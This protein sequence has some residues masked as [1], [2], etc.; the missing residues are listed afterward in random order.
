MNIQNLKLG[1]LAARPVPYML[2]LT[3]YVKTTLPKP[4][5]SIAQ[6]A[7]VQNWGM[8]LNDTLGDCTCAGVGHGIQLLTAEN[9]CLFTPSDADIE[10][11]YEQSCG[12]NPAKPNTDRGGI[13]ADVLDY[14][15][16]HGV[17][18]HS[19]AEHA[20]IHVRSKTDI[21]LGIDLF[22][23]IYIGVALPISAQDQVGKVWDVTKGPESRP[24]TWGGHCIIC[25]D[26]DDV[27]LKC[28]T[29]G[30]VQT[31][32]WTWFKRYCDE[33]HIVLSNDWFTGDK[34]PRGFDSAALKADIAALK[35]A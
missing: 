31:M 35:R 6:S 2:T 17:A 33:A 13:C 14:W 16:E 5:V 12:Y 32:T 1:K 23:F 27:G 18:G 30:A 21:K 3:D 9:N 15:Q 4:P 19:I 29:W 7:D 25:T 28:I 26:Y 8:M 22:G 34:S 10:K 20:P 24:G 11:L